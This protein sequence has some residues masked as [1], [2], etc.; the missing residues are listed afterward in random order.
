MID[1][2]FETE[3]LLV[4]RWRDADIAELQAVYGDAEAMKWVGD[5]RAITAAECDKW[6]IV[7]RR[8][9][10]ERGYGM[11]AVELK[12][13]S[14]VVGF[15]GLVHPDGSADAEVK[16]AY[17]REVWGQG[18]A[19]EALVGLLRYGTTALR[20]RR[21]LATTAPDNV[22][23]H[24]VLSKAGMRRGELRAN[25]DGSETQWFEYSVPAHPQ[26]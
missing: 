8:N 12:S 3:R 10:A 16:Y 7:T 4:R 20:L 11:Y 19:T 26:T 24:A 17:R 23:S 14:Y 1:T 13:A 2:V 9:Y 5:G 6:L 18:L 21:M 22:A 15:C 25:P